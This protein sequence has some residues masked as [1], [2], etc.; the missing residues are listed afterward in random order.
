[1]G[2]FSTKR[3]EK[4]VPVDAPQ[5]S[6]GAPLPAVMASEQCLYVCYLLSAPD[7]Q[8]DGSA[9]R[10]VGPD[11]SGEPIAVVKVK[12][13]RAHTFGPPNDE[14]IGGHRLAKLGLM[15]Y[16]TY[17]V[18]DSLWIAELENANRVHHRHDGR[19]FA[20]LR[21]FIFTFHDSTLEFVS[22]GFE[23]NVTSG[24]IRGVLRDLADAI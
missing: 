15:P 8:W 3:T 20:N 17:E 14:A 2:L 12:H 1:M 18:L 4:L 10:L 6:V 11:S 19:L 7:P 5:S 24:S 13:C 21:H 22:E 9:V 23:V 16:S